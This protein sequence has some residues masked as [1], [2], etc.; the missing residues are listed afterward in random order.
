MSSVE[1]FSS[2]GQLPVRRRRMFFNVFANASINCGD[3]HPLTGEWSKLM[4]LEDGRTEYTAE[5]VAFAQLVIEGK[6]DDANS[7]TL[8]HDA[9]VKKDADGKPTD[10]V[11]A[12][13]ALKDWDSEV[14][15]SLSNS[16]M[17]EHLRVLFPKKFADLTMCQH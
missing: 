13:S 4:K 7:V 5:M 10:I 17:I 16:E 2:E 15:F 1:L 8:L 3:A 11:I 14:I 9:V 6:I 12:Q